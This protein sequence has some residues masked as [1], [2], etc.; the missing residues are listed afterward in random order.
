MSLSWLQRLDL[1][2]SHDTIL[3]PWLDAISCAAPLFVSFVQDIQ[4][5]RLLW[6]KWAMSDDGSRQHHI[7][8]TNTLSGWS[9]PTK[10][11]RV[12]W[13]F[14]SDFVSLW[15]PKTHLRPRSH[16]PFFYGF[17]VWWLRFHEMY[18]FT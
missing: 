16:F 15:I 9:P 2:A 10:T 6:R 7:D 18:D 14:W 5:W 1:L 17:S 13:T 3:A 4:R 12:P 8:S 11:Q